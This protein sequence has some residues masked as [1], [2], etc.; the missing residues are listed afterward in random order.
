LARRAL[1]CALLAALAGAGPRADAEP[2][3]D[4]T[5]NR[6]DLAAL[7]ACG[8]GE[9]N[10]WTVSGLVAYGSANKNFKP[11]VSLKK[12]DSFARSPDFGAPIRRIA[13][14]VRSSSAKYRR[15]A[16]VSPDGAP[17]H[18]CDY[19]SFQSE[20]QFAPCVYVPTNPV[21]RFAFQYDG[22]GHN[23][24]WS[25]ANL[26]VVT[27]ASGLQPPTDLVAAT[28][29]AF[30]RLSWR[31]DAQA[32]SN[33]VDVYRL[34]VAALGSTNEVRR[35]DLSCLVAPSGKLT[36]CSA[37]VE[38]TFG[39]E[40]RGERLYLSGD[41]PGVLRLSTT[42]D[43]GRLVLARPTAA[44][45]LRLV[46]A[47]A[48][49]NDCDETTLVWGLPAQ[50]NV[51]ATLRLTDAFRT[52]LCPLAA[53]KGAAE[54]HLFT[55]RRKTNTRLFV[56]DLAF[57]SLRETQYRRTHVHTGF[58]AHASRFDVRGLVPRRPH[59]FTVTAYAADGAS[60][61]SADSDIFYPARP[62][63]FALVFE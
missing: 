7:A 42:D 22:G 2:A 35:Y 21:R 32:V 36:E 8:T 50:T 40:L 49:T 51:L 17:L 4:E 59:V 24:S 38:Q 20:G 48:T 29:A 5:T 3:A 31:H 28:N 18:V 43:R 1:A 19:T 12:A 34:D 25:I 39:G 6:V 30:T 33:R 54:L 63:G 11:N 55:A 27:G 10:G 41:H 44:T 53:A 58:V 61:R 9:T 45:H 23:T 62:P 26:V 47:R 46:L 52:N 56:K 14:D 57:L 13:F 15:L 60:V 37:L 16:L